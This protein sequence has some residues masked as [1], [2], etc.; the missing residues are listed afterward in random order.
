MGISLD[1]D[2]PPSI[3]ALLA[4]CAATKSH[5]PLRAM[6]RCLGLDVM[7]ED[8]RKLCEYA[9]AILKQKEARKQIKRLEEIL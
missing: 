3:L 2:H 1:K 7:T 4:F 9:R 6:L 8:D 5:E